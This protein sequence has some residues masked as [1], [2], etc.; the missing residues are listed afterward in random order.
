MGHKFSYTNV[1]SHIGSGPYTTRSDNILADLAI[2]H[3]RNNM[4][5]RRTSCSRIPN[6]TILIKSVLKNALSALLLLFWQTLLP[7]QI[8]FNKLYFVEYNYSVLW[9]NKWQVLPC[10]F[11]NAYT[12]THL[13]LYL[14]SQRSVARKNFD[15]GIKLIWYLLI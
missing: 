7:I 9:K 14:P 8:Y 13:W 3:K 11:Q 6:N 4:N 2:K 10:T 12:L 5:K 1:L 15:T